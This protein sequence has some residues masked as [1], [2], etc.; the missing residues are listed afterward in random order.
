VN[1]YVLPRDQDAY[2]TIRGFV[3]QVDLTIL[4]WLDL[5]P[6]QAL[7]LERGEDIDRVAEALAADPKDYDRLLE[8]VKH[9]ERSVTLRDPAALEAIA[10]AIDQR[11][12]NPTLS[13]LFRYTTNARIGTEKPS[14]LPGR[15]P[16]VTVWNQLR[17][18]PPAGMAPAQGLPVLRAFVTG[19]TKP[20]DFAAAR[21]ERL[22]TFFR[23]ST[24]EQL[25]A[26]IR[27]FEWATHAPAML[28]VG[29]R[30]QQILVE[31][32]HAADPAE[33]EQQ[34]ERLF[35]HVF[36][37]LSTPG[38]K[39][40][41]PEGL[42]TQLAAPTL[43]ATD[44]ALLQRVNGR[45]EALELRVGTVEKTLSALGDS[46]QR[47][48]ASEGIT[49]AIR[50]EPPAPVLDLPPLPDRLCRRNGTVA[51]VARE[52]AAHTW[53]VLYG[54]Q[55]SGRSQL[56]SL[57]ARSVGNCR[58]WVR[59]GTGEYNPS[60]LLDRACE[61]LAGGDAPAVRQ[62][63]YRQ[64]CA[65]L[66][67]GSL[68]VI[69]DLPDL[70]RH[71]P[72]G[73][74]LR[75]LAAA[76]CE[77]GV[78]LIATCFQ[79]LPVAFKTTLA[80]ATLKEIPVPP[81]SDEE[82]R[83]LLGAY[84]APPEFLGG[85]RVTLLNTQAAGN[86]LLLATTAE[87][88]AQRNWTP[89]DEDFQGLLR[90]D[91]TGAVGDEV[92]ARLGA[93][94]GD[95]QRD[96]LYRLSLVRA[97]FTLEEVNAL[98]AVPPPV[99]RARESLLALTGP[100]VQRDGEQRFLVSPLMVRLGEESVDPAAKN[101]CHAALGELIVRRE[102]DLA[103]VLRA[104]GHF[105]AAGAF[106]KAGTL[107]VLG[108]KEVHEA[109]D[110]SVGGPLLAVWADTPLPEGMSL[111]LRLL[112]RGLQLAVLA[113]RGGP[114][115]FVLEDIDQLLPRATAQ[116]SWGVLS[117]ALYANIA[118]ARTDP[119]RALRYLR[120]ALRFGTGLVG[121]G[122]ET[123]QVPEEARFERLVWGPVPAVRDEVRLTAWLDTVAVFTPE[124]RQQVFTGE[125][126]ELGCLVLPDRLAAAEVEKPQAEQRWEDVIGVLD[127]LAGRARELGVG[128][129]RACAV[130]TKVRVL[131]EG[132]RQLDEAVRVAREALGAEPE[133]AAQ[134][135]IAAEAGRQ[136][137]GAERYPDAREMLTRSL[138]AD[139]Q[140]YPHERMLVTLAASQAF[141]VEDAARG[142]GL[143][144]QAVELATGNA[145]IPE[146]ELARALSELGLAQFLETGPCAALD[147]WLQA[148]E[149]LFS[150]KADE[151]EWR[152]LFTSF[153]HA[154]LH[155]E[156]LA[157]TGRPPERTGYGEPWAAPFRGMFLRHSRALAERYRPVLEAQLAAILA[158]YAE[159]CS[160]AAKA[161]TWHLRAR[162]AAATRPSELAARTQLRAVPTLVGQGRYEEA[163]RAAREGAQTVLAIRKE[164]TA[165]RD[166][167]RADFDLN[168]AVAALEESDRKGVDESAAQIVLIPAILRTCTLSVA[169]G[170]QGAVNAAQLAAV[171][172]SVSVSAADATLWNL[173]REILELSWSGGAAHSEIAD[174]ALSAEARAR[175]V[176]QVAARLCAGRH[177]QIGEAFMGQLSV[178]PTLA[179][180]YPPGSA[181]YRRLLLPFVEAFW[182]DALDKQR[183][184]IRSPE[185]VQGAFH[186]ACEG[187][188]AARLRA[189]FRALQIG[190]RVSGIPPAIVRWLEGE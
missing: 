68:L 13:L 161:D 137:V 24:D 116:D 21:W 151:D 108:L 127:R 174:K 167:E 119:V 122:G 91:H 45:V 82:A 114:L 97:P 155:F 130:R 148:A 182:T 165:G 77:T 189:I 42:A 179:S 65:G 48:A 38:L 86:P 117:V 104:L 168:A 16:L 29:G 138:A 15:T 166:P 25:L 94:V 149:R 17:S 74:R 14:P 128:L 44:R 57:V 33:A 105:S 58:A 55:S 37:L 35:L 177:A 96:L 60:V 144:R 131:A 2:A 73:D 5:R 111:G 134:F 22:T 190:I 173:C 183:A 102:M 10:N 36:K 154:S 136:L 106:D 118:I 178:M 23:T 49:G 146:I 59:L 112:V 32:G 26:L 107:L 72:L 103:D 78:R 109:R 75:E 132:L 110:A 61:E 145:G 50:A 63:W 12:S 115:S 3:Y 28:S 125:L 20:E 188:P 34:Y 99:G 152:S 120:E 184:F 84:G 126:A 160:D 95:A 90:G 175:P 11:S 51:V 19:L 52:V 163:I 30:V 27:D 40:L 171:C 153:A 180:W 93:T 158:N 56:A 71:A 39:R 181:V 100:W 143:A 8:Q 187:P 92:L 98:A 113:Q 41:T 7:E 81:F 79:V 4:R 157:S 88:L 67:A 147:T 54:A 121:P 162:E 164:R 176:V 186:E 70:T 69:D 9:R 46:F 141:G 133:P 89:T 6:G 150:S 170:A 47:F 135:L 159:G 185:L 142:T 62:P 172:A 87:Y 129:L 80:G 76:C 83:E 156:Q 139:T 123:L 43:A 140:V 85:G 101:G 169:D 53:T 66:G 124:A 18:G 64:M 31:R 1:D